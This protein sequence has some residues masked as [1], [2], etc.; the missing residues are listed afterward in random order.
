M[1]INTISRRSSVS[2]LDENMDNHSS[3]CSHYYLLYRLLGSQSVST[4]VLSLGWLFVSLTRHC[5]PKC[6]WSYKS[7][8]D[9][10]FVPFESK[11]EIQSCKRHV[12]VQR[13]CCPWAYSC[14]YVANFLD[15][16]SRPTSGSCWRRTQAP[17]KC[18]WRECYLVQLDESTSS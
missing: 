18:T 5:P 3:A 15:S 12:T 9:C 7:L 14:R 16:K 10:F 8:S 4:R 2:P 17:V 6:Q 1:T 11:L 13:N